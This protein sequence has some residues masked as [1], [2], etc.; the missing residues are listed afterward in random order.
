ML[1]ALEARTPSLAADP[2]RRGDPVTAAPGLAASAGPAAARA[3]DYGPKHLYAWCKR[4]RICEPKNGCAQS[5]GPKAGWLY[6]LKLIYS[7]YIK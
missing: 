3:F 2:R 6:F 4:E 5:I 1:V 7:K